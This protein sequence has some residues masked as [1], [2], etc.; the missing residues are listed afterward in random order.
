M[1]TEFN[2][3]KPGVDIFKTGGVVLTDRQTDPHSSVNFNFPLPVFEDGV[4]LFLGRTRDPK[5]L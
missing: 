2:A 3:K 1:G 4:L 5:Q